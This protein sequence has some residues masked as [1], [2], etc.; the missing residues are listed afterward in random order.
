MLIRDYQPGDFP[1]IEALW[2]ETGIYTVER[3]D[4]P[5]SIERCK[6]MG[7]RFL[8]MEDP[9]TGDIVA[10]SWLTVDGRRI[11]LHHFAVL[12]SCQNQGLGRMLALKSL[13]IAREE[14]YP[15]KLEVHAE[16]RPAVHLYESLGFKLFEGY[17]VYIIY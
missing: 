17:N 5:E 15:V 14:G 7:G 12:P 13:E 3:G 1:Q 11:F 9:G 6:L 4:T 8:V 16:N 10:T 2:K